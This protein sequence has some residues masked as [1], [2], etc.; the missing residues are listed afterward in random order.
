MQRGPLLDEWGTRNREKQLRRIYRHDYNW[1]VQGAFAGLLK[2]VASTPWEIRG[3]EN[4]SGDASKW[5]SERIKA[6]GKVADS[7]RPDIEYY[8]ELLRQADWGRGWT[9]F[10]KKGIDYLRQDG[11]WYWEIVAP[12]TPTGAP[13]APPTMIAHLDSLRC[14][15]TGDPEFP[16]VYTDRKGILHMLP[17]GRV[18]HL[19]DMP[20]GDESLPGYGLCALSRAASISAREVLMGR[21]IESHLDDK[22]APGI[23]SVS[24]MT[25]AHR[26][27][28]FAAYRDEQARDEQAPWGKTIWLY[29]ADPSIPLNI[30]TTNFQQPPEKFDY[31]TYTEINVNA[32]ALALGVDVQDLWQLSGGN[33][34]SGAQSEILHAKSKGKALGD[35]YAQI[36]RA[37]N[38]ILPEEYEFTFK[39]RDEQEDI[40][41]AQ[42]A[43]QWTGAVATARNDLQ[44][45]EARQ[46]LANNVPG[47]H[48]AITDENGE[49]I[50]VDDKDVGPQE[51][52]PDEVIAQQQLL[53]D[54]AKPNDEQTQEQSP[55]SATTPKAQQPPSDTPEPVE[56]TTPTTTTE[57]KKPDADDEDTQDIKE[58]QAMLDAG[59][60]TIGEAQER[61]GQTPD[62]AL[63]GLYLVDGVP[64]PRERI[65]DL[66]Q[67]RFGRG[68]VSFDA[69][70]SGDTETDETK[71][72]ALDTGVGRRSDADLGERTKAF[73]ATRATFVTNFA[74]LLRAATTGDSPNR[75]RFG[76]QAR[77]LLRRHGLEAFRDGLEEGGVKDRELSDDD[78]DTFST[79]LA[80]QSM[81]VADTSQRIFK[82]DEAVNP[83][84]SAERWANKS[85]QRSFDL[86]RLSADAN[87]MYE[88]VGP[89]KPGSCRHCKVLK[90]QRHRLKD[91]IRTG[92][93]PKSD[94][95]DCGGFN[96]VDKLVKTDGTTH[97]RF[98]RG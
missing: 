11:G 9:S 78:F 79:W 21:Y 17:A 1:M 45:N 62:P 51:G 46:I 5:W 34:G 16:A 67:A 88:F 10:I 74:D 60:I 65:G 42:V 76:I 8:Q 44:D 95:L 82:S 30:T 69:V 41:E 59:L 97:G 50:R 48:D 86:G 87:G 4:I 12:G 29:G 37:I 24:G 39:A 98:P 77:G 54:G 61:M 94:K 2:R 32:L 96:C 80:E 90:G 26:D 31:K 40:H 71:P 25:Q 33:L 36:E 75:R 14:F 57:E 43:T 85:L 19:V 35:L 38:D 15:P 3:P 20:D 56:A 63:A 64:V 28:A 83:D 92:W 91:Y 84:I 47:F 52:M 93:L 22:P 7:S 49:L 81:F 18:V 55:Q 27:K 6:L 89:V 73:Q 66:W 13:T 70:V 53:I 23:A 72:K 68:V 58:V